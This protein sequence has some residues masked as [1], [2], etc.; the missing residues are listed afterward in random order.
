MER[1]L[2][3][4][5]KYKPKPKTKAKRKAKP[6]MTAKQ[7]RFCE[8]Y[9]K[10]QCAAKAAKAAGYSPKTAKNI[11]SQNLAKLHIK[12]HIAKLQSALS[13]TTKLDSEWVLKRLEKEADSALNTA[14]DRIRATE[15]IAKHLGMF[16]EKHEH[17]GKDGGPIETTEVPHES[18]HDQIEGYADLFRRGVRPGSNGAVRKNGVRQSVDPEQT[19]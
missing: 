10:L 5:K 1:V 6:K 15:L 11:G 12:S 19:N 3:A 4:K 18:I 8:E 14:R 7:K 16:T 2:M 13:K 17:T 9:I